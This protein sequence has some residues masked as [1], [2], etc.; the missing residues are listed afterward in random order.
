MSAGLPLQ[1]GVKVKDGH[2]PFVAF[3]QPTTGITNV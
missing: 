1:F 2:C 3:R